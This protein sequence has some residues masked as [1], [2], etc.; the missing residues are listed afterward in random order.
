MEAYGKKNAVFSV[1]IELHNDF[2]QT[3][4]SKGINMSIVIEKAMGSFIR[5]IKNPK[6]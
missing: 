4:A 1:D 2:K 3:C 6:S 5:R